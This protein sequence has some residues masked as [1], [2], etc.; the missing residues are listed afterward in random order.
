MD[1]T[2]RCLD[3]ESRQHVQL[4]SGHTDKIRCLSFQPGSEHNFMS[5]GEDHKVFMWDMRSSSYTKQFDKLESPLIAYDPAGL[6]FAMSRSTERIEIYDVRMLREKPC[7]KFIYEA[8][9]LIKWTHLIFSPDGKRILLSSDYSL[10]FSV[11]AFN[12]SFYQAY[13]GYSNESRLPLQASYSAD[14]KFVLSGADAGRVH[15]WDESSG[16]LLAVLLSNSFHPVRCLQFHPKIAMFVSSDVMTLF[17]LPRGDGQYEFVKETKAEPKSSN[18]IPTIDLTVTDDSDQEEA[19]HVG[20]QINRQQMRRNRVRR[21]LSSSLEEG[22][23][24]DGD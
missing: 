12:G 17:W 20:G 3:L 15:V 24:P 1:H 5:A 8:N 9:N 4:F 10:C 22:E 2:I 18:D 13:T 23:L 14:S 21:R 19:P 11:D 7:Q 16:E 6:V